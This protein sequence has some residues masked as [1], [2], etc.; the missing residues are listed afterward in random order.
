MDGYAT[1]RDYAAIGD[2]RTAALVARDG[3]VDWLCLPDLDSPSVF[4]AILD[5]GEGGRFS[6]APE[7]PFESERRYLP[8]TN[9]LETTFRTAD[10]AVRVT[11]AMT[12]PGTGLTPLREL[13]RSVE[14]LAGS[15]PLAWSVEPRFGYAAAPTRVSRRNGIAVAHAGADALA[16]GAWD[17]GD[18]ELGRGTVAGR[19]RVR[20]GDRALLALTAAH[21]E[22]LVFVSRDEVEARL[23]ATVEFWREWARKRDHGGPWRDQ[24]IRSAL[25]LKLLVY[26]PSGAIAAAATTSL[27]EDVGGERNWDYRFCWI[28]DSVFTLEALLD[29]GCP[30][31]AHAFFWWLMHASQLTHPRLQVLYRLDGGNRAPER[32]LPLAGYRGSRPVRIG[33]G[34][35]DQRQLDVYGDLFQAVWVYVQRGNELDAD[36][37][38]RLA[39][40]AD[41]VCDLWRRP[42]RGL[43]EVRSE[44][45][46]FVQSKMMCWVALDRAVRLAEAGLVPGRHAARWRREAGAVRAFVEEEGYSE[47]RGSYVRVAG[48]DE[49]DAGLLLGSLLGYCD[50]DDPRMLGTLEAIRR[51]LGHGPYLHRYRGD[52][53]LRGREG[54]FLCCSFWLVEA[55]ARAGRLDEAADL[56]ERLLPLAN[57]VGLYAEEIDA[58]TGEFLGNFPQGLTH[59]ALVSAAAAWARAAGA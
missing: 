32:E 52:D 8:E 26:S 29:I 13:A 22:P 40:K 54:A 36:S 37:G 58:E 24:V 5:A 33:N 59:L 19:F 2:G 43:W 16:V 11:D 18:P 47:R 31:E 30:A 28:R 21:E 6:L 25:A 20:A 14:G 50:G 46:H 4:A 15:V 7:E 57:D 48:G 10:G 23:A 3:S 44:P 35:V 9:V 49:L 38:R 51:E 34:A 41:L 12:L 42:D 45:V 53:G 39:L 27:P 55:L 1:I 17:A 56:M